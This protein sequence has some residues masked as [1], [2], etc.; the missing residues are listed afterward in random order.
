MS[1]T[2]KKAIISAVNYVIR[3]YFFSIITAIGTI[4]LT[5]IN[6]QTG[7]ITIPWAI[8]RA[9]F[10]FNTVVFIIGAVDKLK[11]TYLSEEH[12]KLNDGKSVGIVPSIIQIEN[13]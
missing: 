2:L 13:K 10:L 6:I 9:V 5:G 3:E 8:L 4:V 7:T 1:D 11:H 12:P